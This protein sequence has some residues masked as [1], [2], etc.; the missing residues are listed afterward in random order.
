MLDVLSFPHFLVFQQKYPCGCSSVAFC[1]SVLHV[2]GNGWQSRIWNPGCL[3]LNLHLEVL[4]PISWLCLPSHQVFFTAFSKSHGA[5]V[6]KCLQERGQGS[7]H[8]S[9]SPVATKQTL[10][11]QS[12]SHLLPTLYPL[13]GPCWGNSLSLCAS[14]QMGSWKLLARR[15]VAESKRSLC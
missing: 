14:R 2:M 11:E 1:T 7:L 4:R 13:C 5:G 12:S 10:Q 9:F 3:L 15:T 6:R 8:P